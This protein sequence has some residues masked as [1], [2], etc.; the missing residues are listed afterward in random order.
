MIFSIFTFLQRLCQPLIL[1]AYLAKKNIFKNVQTIYIDNS[2]NDVT[3]ND[4]SSID[5]FNDPKFGE[6]IYNLA[7]EG[8]IPASSQT[9]S[10]ILKSGKFQE[11]FC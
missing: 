4:V 10:F 2:A 7:N 8:K 1:A 11:I 3:K 9:A 6:T 5:V